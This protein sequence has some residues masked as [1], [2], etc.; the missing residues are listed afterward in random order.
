M[1]LG[2]HAGIRYSEEASWVGLGW[3][4]QPGAVTRGIREV[5][6]DYNGDKVL[7]IAES[8]KR[9]RHLLGANIAGGLLY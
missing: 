8:I 7:D 6:D 5:P 2:Y 9:T 3:N 1:S 4:L